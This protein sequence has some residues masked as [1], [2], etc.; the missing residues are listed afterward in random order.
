M[1]LCP[2]LDSSQR[3]SKRPTSEK[4]PPDN[5]I[6]VLVDDTA[7]DSCGWRSVFPS[8]ANKKSPASVDWLYVTLRNHDQK[9]GRS[10]SGY[11]RLR[12]GGY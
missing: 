5:C 10:T 2:R 6:G 4:Q 11:Y 8:G 9:A 1:A 3:T 7:P 12:P